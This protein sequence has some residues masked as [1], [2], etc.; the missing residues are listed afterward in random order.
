MHKRAFPLQRC[1]AFKIETPIMFLF[2]VY[3]PRD[4]NCVDQWKR[5][6]SSSRS[7]NCSTDSWKYHWNR[8]GSER[9]Y[10][11]RCWYSFWSSRSAMKRWIQNLGLFVFCATHVQQATAPNRNNFLYLSAILTH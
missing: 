10:C 7:S 5:S 6:T 9:S 8:A 3:Y 1:V 11:I 4:S 2:F